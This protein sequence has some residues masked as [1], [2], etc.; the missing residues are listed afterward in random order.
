MP[1]DNTAH[2]KEKRKK[3]I[4]T[5]SPATDPDMKEVREREKRKQT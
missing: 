4:K 1:Y 3:K 5:R 2:Y